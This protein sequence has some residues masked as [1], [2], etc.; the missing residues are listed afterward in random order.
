LDTNSLQVEWLGAEDV[1]HDDRGSSFGGR[2]ARVFRVKNRLTCNLRRAIVWLSNGASP[3]I[4]K[5]SYFFND[6]FGFSRNHITVGSHHCR[7]IRT[8]SDVNPTSL[9][10][11]HQC[12]FI[13]TSNDVNPHH[14]RYVT[15][16]SKSSSE[17]GFQPTVTSRSRVVRVPHQW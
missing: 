5:N 2:E 10:D 8:I 16:G 3:G 17:G 12:R 9:P 15:V 6:F 7:F 1:K 13:R 14:C 11:S 4:K